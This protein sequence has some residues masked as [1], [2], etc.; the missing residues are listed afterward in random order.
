MSTSKIIKKI[1]IKFQ[2]E[3]IKQ[4]L[5]VNYKVIDRADLSNFSIKFISI[6]FHM[7]KVRLKSAISLITPFLESAHLE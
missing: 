1:L 2:I 5:I 6:G 7:K 4:S 3:K